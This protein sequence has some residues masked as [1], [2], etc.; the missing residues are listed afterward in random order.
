MR[1][2]QQAH[3]D[4]PDLPVLPVQRG[5]WAPQ[6]LP[7]RSAQPDLRESRGRGWRSSTSTR[8][9]RLWRRRSRSRRWGP[10]TMWARRRPTT[11]TPTP[12]PGGR[13]AASS[14]A[15]RGPPAQRGLPARY[16]V[17]RVPQA[18]RALP[19]PPERT[20]QRRVPP[21]PQAKQA[22]PDLPVPRGQRGP[23]GLPARCRGR[24]APRDQQ[25]PRVPTDLQ[26]RT[27]RYQAPPARRAQ[28]GRRVPRGQQVPRAGPDPRGRQVLRE[29]I[30]RCL[31]PQGPREH[32]DR[33]GRRDRRE[34]PV[35][36][37]GQRVLRAPQEPQAPPDRRAP[38]T[39]PT[40]RQP[41]SPPLDGAAT[42]RPSPSTGSSP[43]PV[44]RT[45]TSPARTRP[46]PTRGRRGACGA[47]ILP[48]PT[49]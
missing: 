29:R 16:R 17:Q 40:A 12:S 44:P 3:R 31:V 43:T 27:A 8:A 10:T 30:V 14:R 9:K 20:V 32:R 39:N 41:P 15:R 18:P 38:L 33:P 47:V 26:A 25:D 36:Y 37:R 42:A 13:T 21:V 5:R 7:G 1:R 46:A 4:Q 48:G 22:P 49:A 34:L 24:Q 45:L 35:P 19:A 28:Q 23:P 11:S 2:G 6:V